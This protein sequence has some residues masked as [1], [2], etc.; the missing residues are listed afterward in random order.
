MAHAYRPL[1]ESSASGGDSGEFRLIELRRGASGEPIVCKLHHYPL[2]QAPQYDA[3][4]YVWGDPTDTR[5]IS[6]PAGSIQIT[7][8]LHSALQQFRH[9]DRE[10]LLWADAICINQADIV[11]RGHQVAVMRK[12]YNGASNVLIW[13]GGETGTDEDAFGAI[14]ILNEKL[15]L[16]YGLLQETRANVS[17]ADINAAGQFL[18]KPRWQALGRLFENPWFSR[19]WVIQE[20]AYGKDAMVFRGS[21]SVSWTIFRS[22]ASRILGHHLSNWLEASQPDAMVDTLRHISTVMRRDIAFQNDFFKMLCL[23]RTFKSTDPRDK[24]Y[25]LLGMSTDPVARRIRPDYTKDI[26]SVFVEFTVADMTAQTSLR[27]IIV[28]PSYARSESMDL[29]SWVPDW[30]QAPAAMNFDFIATYRASG[31]VPPRFSV[32]RDGRVLYVTGKHLSSPAKIGKTISEIQAVNEHL[33]ATGQQRQPTFKWIYDWLTDCH[34]VA[35][36]ENVNISRDFCDTDEYT[37]FLK[38]LC[39]ELDYDVSTPPFD[40]YLRSIR[41]MY[42]HAKTLLGLYNPDATLQSDSYYNVASVFSQ[43][44]LVLQRDVL[45]SVLL[46]RFC[47]LA[48]GQIGWVSPDTRLTDTVSVLYGCRHPLVLR[49]VDEIHVKLV[50]D[51]Y[52]QGLMDGQALRSNSFSETE[53]KIK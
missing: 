38:A 20:V 22:V 51:C 26:T 42:R 11:E 33:N 3:I 50:G 7:N 37:A 44:V 17:M 9:P 36:G 25:A 4:S 1:Q 6:S 49:P 30:T 13:L 2:D 29:P 53:F 52:F 23:C 34:G 14:D 41:Y 8:N 16:E 12:I 48:T 15:P 40:S 19:V 43:Q 24:I 27:H 45:N 18:S 10:R 46:K 35:F 28:A 31:D 21:R 39:C 5:E 32:S 47:R